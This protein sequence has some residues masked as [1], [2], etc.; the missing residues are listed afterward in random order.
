MARFRKNETVRVPCRVEPGPFEGESLIM[1]DT[2]SGPISG[3]VRAQFLE[4]V[5]DQPDRGFILATVLEERGTMVKVRLPGSFFTTAGI[6]SVTAS[7]L[8]PGTR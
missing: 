8:R 2:P 3:F 7:E 6:A 5:P 4:K 1:I